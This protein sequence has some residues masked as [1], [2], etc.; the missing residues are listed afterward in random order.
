MY[1]T[2]Y[3]YKKQNALYLDT[4]FPSGCCAHM[5]TIRTS[6]HECKRKKKRLLLG[7]SPGRFSTCWSSAQC[8]SHSVSKLHSFYRKDSLKVHHRQ[9]LKIWNLLGGDFQAGF[10]G[11]H[12][13]S[14]SA[15]VSASRICFANHQFWVSLSVHHREGWVKVWKITSQQSSFCA[16]H[17]IKQQRTYT[18]QFS[19]KTHAGAVF[20]PSF[21]WYVVEDIPTI[22]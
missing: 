18:H 1:L 13:F 7:Q 4:Y 20:T 2:S 3:I 16:K 14:I 21:M 11:F 5:C 10:L 19:H 15:R 22:F 6:C 9:W 12:K 8:Y 17:T